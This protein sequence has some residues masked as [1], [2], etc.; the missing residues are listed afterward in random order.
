MS[1]VAEG[2]HGI[3][4]ARV[5]VY[6]YFRD[7]DLPCRD[8][9][10][11]IDYNIHHLNVKGGSVQNRY[12]YIIINSIFSPEQLYSKLQ[13]D[14]PKKQWLRRM[15]VKRISFDQ[16]VLPLAEHGASVSSSVCASV[17]LP[18]PMICGS[19]ASRQTVL[20][21]YFGGASVAASASVNPFAGVNSFGDFGD[22]IK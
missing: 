5:A 6:G 7:T 12:K 9:I 21:S 3:D 20:E 2:L 13:S 18:S 1:C 17:F 14:E 15:V 11:F 10:N 8:F 16:V 22:P 4:S 19:A